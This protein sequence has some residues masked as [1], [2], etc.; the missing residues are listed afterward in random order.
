MTAVPVPANAPVLRLDAVSAGYG[1]TTVLRSITIEVAPASVVALLGPNGAGKTTTLGVASGLI[2]PQAGTITLG[3]FPATGLTSY[4]RSRRGLCLIP[5][6]R[7][8][9]RSLTVKENLLLSIPPWRKGASAERAYEAFPI[10]A[11]RKGQTAGTLS[12]GQQQMLAIAR[13]YLSDPKVVLLDEV[14][15]GLA[16]IIVDEIFESLKV[17]AR[18]GVSLLLVEQ[19]VKRALALADRV[20]LLNRGE[21]SFAGTPSELDEAELT[22]R[23]LGL[24]S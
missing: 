2:R 21:I 10:L 7:G 17:L 14:S 19:Y 1:R 8:I 6:G 13:A 16:P 5:E 18:A 23:Y 12:G 9:F 11:Q 22:G 4:E 3:S 15:M 24:G 20:Y